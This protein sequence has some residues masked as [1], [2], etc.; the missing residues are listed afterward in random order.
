MYNNLAEGDMV[1][2]ATA[3][4]KNVYDLIVEKTEDVRGNKQP[5]FA[6]NKYN[7]KSLTPIDSYRV[8]DVVKNGKPMETPPISEK[9]DKDGKDNLSDISDKVKDEINSLISDDNMKNYDRN[10]LFE[11]SEDPDNCG[12]N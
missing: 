8:I 12:T 1:S 11:D 7:I 5:I 4:G 3:D 2:V 6:K 10:N 9:A